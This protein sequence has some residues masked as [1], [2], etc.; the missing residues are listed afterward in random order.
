MLHFRD[1][2]TND[3]IIDI[4]YYYEYFKNT[5]IISFSKTQIFVIKFLF[6]YFFLEIN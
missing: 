3:N 2:H 1:F 6:F 5:L 4:T